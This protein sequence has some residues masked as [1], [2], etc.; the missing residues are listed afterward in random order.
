M[1]SG[2]EDE[3]PIFVEGPEKTWTSGSAWEPDNQGVFGDVGLR[4][5]E[6]VVDALVIEEVNIEVTCYSQNELPE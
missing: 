4:L 5:E 2:V 3:R 6:E 1:G